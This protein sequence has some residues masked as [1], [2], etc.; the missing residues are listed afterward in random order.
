MIALQK[1]LDALA[2]DPEAEARRHAAAG[3]R[4]VGVLGGAAP[5]ELIEA[6]DAFPLR[7]R[8]DPAG[9][10]DAADAWMEPV[11]EGALRSIFNQ[12]LTGG[13]DW[14]DLIVVPRSSEQLVQFY[15]LAEHVRAE[16][17]DLAMPPLHL[18]NL[19]QTP[20]ARSTRFNRR[21]ME[22]LAEALGSLTGTR[23][24]RIR[25]REAIQWRNTLR[26]LASEVSSARRSADRSVSGQ[27]AALLFLAGQVRPA[28]QAAEMFGRAG[29]LAASRSG[30]RLLLSGSGQENPGLVRL[31]EEAGARVVAED[32]DW[33]ERLYDHEVEEAPDPLDGLVR[34]Y[35]CHAPT[36]RL[37]VGVTEARFTALL[38]AARPDG[39]VFALEENDDTLGWD[40]PRRLDLLKDRGIPALVLL[41][42]SFFR[43]DPETASKLVTFLEPLKE[44]TR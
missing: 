27:D 40:I 6:A 21:E 13:L 42:L 38:D 23:P 26:H 14:L 5:V 12:L 34:H 1:Q 20:E 28:P 35:Q 9:P 2:A 15:H 39:V 30:P 17:P 11:Q 24:D 4:V 44:A 37:P 41:R 7:L 25:L 33:G 10:T 16:E 43:E 36:P 31:I 3:G 22:R 32:H 19:L 29:D 8:G 18:V